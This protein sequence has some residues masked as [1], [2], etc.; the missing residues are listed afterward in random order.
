M[1]PSAWIAFLIARG[2]IVDLVAFP[3][4]CTF[5]D[6]IQAKFATQCFKV[7]STKIC[8]KVEKENQTVSHK[9]VIK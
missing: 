7:N 8:K 4:Q 9:Y 2:V 1:Q 3:V 6:S 5:E